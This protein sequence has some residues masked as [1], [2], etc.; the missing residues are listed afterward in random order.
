MCFS[1]K[2]RPLWKRPAELVPIQSSG[3]ELENQKVARRERGFRILQTLSPNPFNHLRLW[4]LV[5]WKTTGVYKHTCKAPRLPLKPGSEK[6]HKHGG[7]TAWYDRAI[8]LWSKCDHFLIYSWCQGAGLELRVRQE[9]VWVLEFTSVSI[10]LILFEECCIFDS[11]HMPSVYL[12]QRGLLIAKKKIFTVVFLNFL[13]VLEKCCP[14]ILNMTWGWGGGFNC[15]CQIN[16]VFMYVWMEC[17]SIIMSIKNKFKP[18][19]RVYNC[20]YKNS[21]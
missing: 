5:T 7:L 18:K 8:V 20:Y 17:G 6:S 12:Y 9:L 3:L 21:L 10:Y 15:N 11:Q 2:R 4:A 14:L 13:K 19:F 1:E 16:Y